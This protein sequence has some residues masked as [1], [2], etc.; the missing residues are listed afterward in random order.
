MNNVLFITGAAKGIGF[1]IACHFAKK[2]A[3]V[4]ITDLSEDALAEAKAKI[5]GTVETFVCDV[6]DEEAIKQAIAHTVKTF[7][8]IDILI[9]NAGLQH[10]EKIEHFPTDQFEKMIQIM[11]VAPFLT[12][13]YVLPIMKEQQYG[14]IINIAS[15]NG[16]IG[17]EG[18]AAYNAAKHGVIGLT[19]VAALETATDGI[20]VNALCPG[21]IQ[22]GM[23]ENQ[24][25]ELAK[26]KGISLEEAKEYLFSLIPQNRLLDVSEISSLALYLASKEAKGLTGQAIVI[27]GGYTA[28]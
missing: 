15:I 19:K 16:V 17:F 7:G 21:Y 5:T 2:G 26:L 11:L 14:R 12:M 8:T 20:T 18:K 1:D 9:N 27:D 22:T 23:V 24:Y 6:S 25:K 13:K 3:S 4:M 10:V 28:Q